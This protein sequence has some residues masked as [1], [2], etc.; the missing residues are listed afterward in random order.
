MR[1]RRIIPFVL[2]IAVL[3]CGYADNKRGY[4]GYR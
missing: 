1:I 4:I 2:A 3:F